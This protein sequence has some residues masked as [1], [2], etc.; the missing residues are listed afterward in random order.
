M[1]PINIKYTAGWF[2]ENSACTKEDEYEEF[3][4]N[5]KMLTLWYK[6]HKEQANARPSKLQRLFAWSKER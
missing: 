1:K 2:L 5:K 3:L 4:I 6:I